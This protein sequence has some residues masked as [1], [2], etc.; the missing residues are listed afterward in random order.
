MSGQSM[1]TYLKSMKW[2]AKP[3]FQ[4][5]LAG[6]LIGNLIAVFLTAL[7]PSSPYYYPK[8]YTYHEMK[9]SNGVKLH[10]LNTVPQNIALKPITS[11]V[12]LT[13]ET[14][15]NG[16]FFWNGDLLSIA[17]VNDQPLKGQQEDYGSG[18]YNIDLPKGTLVWDEITRRFTVQVVQD[19]HE[20]KVTDKQHYWAQ[21]G[22]SMSLQDDSHWDL[23]AISE[24]MP[25]F[26]EQRLRSGVVYDK[27][28]TVWLIVTDTPSTAEQFRTAVVEMIG[29][30]NAVDGVFL[31]GDGSSQMRSMQKQLKGDSREVYQMLALKQK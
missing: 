20:L 28:Q 3:R 22:I 4:L 16:G 24:D 14:G 31:D 13:D 7:P 26:D 6:F 12:T 8:Y 10:T 18:W 1:F 19:A 5:L 2:L 15:I 17:V 23:Q 25:A 27:Q 9:A 11:N 30:G 21:G 29:R